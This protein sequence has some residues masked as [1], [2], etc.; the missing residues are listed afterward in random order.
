LDGAGF[1]RDIV[2]GAGEFAPATSAGRAPP[3]HEQ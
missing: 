2:F 1:G 3:A